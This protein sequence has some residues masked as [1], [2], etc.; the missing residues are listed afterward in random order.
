[1]R[2]FWSPLY[3]GITVTAIVDA[4]QQFLAAPDERKSI[5]IRSPAPVLV[6]VSL[7][8]SLL[9]VLD[10]RRAEKYFNPLGLLLKFRDA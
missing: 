6:R 1:L 2:S 5:L 7:T 8:M 4:N 10:A 9:L 3:V